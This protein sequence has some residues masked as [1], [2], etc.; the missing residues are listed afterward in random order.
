MSCGY[1]NYT[2]S[3]MT[4]S[5]CPIS[6]YNEPMLRPVMTAQPP[7]G[8]MDCTAEIIILM[9][10]HIK[11]FLNIDFARLLGYINIENYV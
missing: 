1:F 10:P 8:Q 3:A 9:L 6:F 2:T 5:I 11:A 4:L 7:R